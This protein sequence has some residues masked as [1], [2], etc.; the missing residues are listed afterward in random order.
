MLMIEL[1]DMRAIS[2]LHVA[3]FLQMNFSIYCYQAFADLWSKKM[4]K[5]GQT[6]NRQFSTINGLILGYVNRHFEKL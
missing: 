1:F 3:I 5:L 4:R 6:W 2:V